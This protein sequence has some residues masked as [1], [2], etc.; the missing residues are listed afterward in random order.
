MIWSTSACPGGFGM[1]TVIFDVIG[2]TRNLI[3]VLRRCRN[4]PLVERSLCR[5]GGE[6]TVHVYS[7]PYLPTYLV[8]TYLVTNQFHRSCGAHHTCGSRPR[9]SICPF[10]P[11]GVVRPTYP[12]VCLSRITPPSTHPTSL[13]F[14]SCRAC[15]VPHLLRGKNRREFPDSVLSARG[16]PGPYRAVSGSCRTVLCCIASRRGHDEAGRGVS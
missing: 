2:A 12:P 10:F 14:F 1:G 16:A 8:L 9:P 5:S 4:S 15:L 11:Q 6:S 13:P 3:G 7:Q